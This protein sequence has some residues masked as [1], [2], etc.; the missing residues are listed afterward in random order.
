MN[1]ILPPQYNKTFSV[2]QDKAPTV[3]FAE[4]EKMFLEE[5]GKKPSEIFEYFDENAIASASIAQVHRARLKDGTNV[6]VKVQ[7]PYIRN[8]IP[9]DL[10]C[11]RIMLWCYEK[12]FNLPMYWS[13]DYTC[14]N[15]RKEADF[16]NE[17]HNSERAARNLKDRSDVHIPKVFWEHSTSRILTCEWIDGV[18]MNDEQGLAKLNLPKK[19]IVQSMIELFA[20]QIFLSG[21]V[22]CDPHPGSFCPIIQDSKPSNIKS[23]QKLFLIEPHPFFLFPFFFLMMKFRKYFGTKTG[24]WEAS[25]GSVGP[26]AIH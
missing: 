8:Q 23:K 2:L 3:P 24:E 19:P 20:H 11:Y 1:H 10:T 17:A 21:F 4:V 16:L 7:K 22:H 6:A 9:A 5:F 14:Q 18:K 12:I 25:I 15:L 13:A 26:R